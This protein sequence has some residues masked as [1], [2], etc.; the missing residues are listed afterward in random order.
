MAK[1]AIAI[2]N[3]VTE[4]PT[5]NKRY[6]YSH[7]PWGWGGV[8]TRLFRIWLFEKIFRPGNIYFYDIAGFWFWV[9]HII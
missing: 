9:G 7:G 5:L 4:G 3:S 1:P 8:S 2:G 6:W